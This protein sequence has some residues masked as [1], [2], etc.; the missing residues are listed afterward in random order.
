VALFRA[1]PAPALISRCG[2]VS[3]HGRDPEGTLIPNTAVP[4]FIRVEP[5]GG[6]ADTT[7]TEAGSPVEKVWFQWEIILSRWYPRACLGHDTTEDERIAVCYQGHADRSTSQC[8]GAC[9]WSLSSCGAD[10]RSDGRRVW[11][12]Q[13]LF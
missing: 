8:N 5:L 10:R 4:G 7:L 6:D 3:Q 2:T 1:G 12:R 9:R 13:K 11:S